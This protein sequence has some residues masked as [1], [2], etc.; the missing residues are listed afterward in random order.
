MRLRWAT[1]TT[2]VSTPAEITVVATTIT[3][4]SVSSSSSSASSQAT[5]PSSIR[6]GAIAGIVV[7]IVAL[8]LVVS[9]LLF[10]VW[11]RRR[12]Q[13]H[14]LPADQ[15]AV[16]QQH[17]KNWHTAKHEADTRH[18]PSETGFPN[19]MEGMRNR[20]VEMAG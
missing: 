8:V 1:C 5:T 15:A 4:G 20:A 12:Q 19:E 2:V 3:A 17:E 11:G 7:A 16:T 10:F 14:G 9:G 18:P 13:Q 6:I